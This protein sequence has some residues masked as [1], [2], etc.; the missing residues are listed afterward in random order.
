[1]ARGGDT[2]TDHSRMNESS[3]PVVVVVGQRI[4]RLGRLR[5]IIKS[6]LVTLSSLESRGAL[7]ADERRPPT[8]YVCLRSPFY[9][10]AISPVF[11]GSSSR[12]YHR[13]RPLC[14][15]LFLDDSRCNL[16]HRDHKVLSEHT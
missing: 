7:E 13:E 6:A 1:M 11:L 4:R 15:F 12:Y 3:V 10:A 16:F 2:V 5:L 8:R 9:A 14:G